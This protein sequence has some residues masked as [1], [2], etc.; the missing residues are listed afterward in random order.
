MTLTKTGKGR[1]TMTIPTPEEC[2][3][4]YKTFLLNLQSIEVHSRLLH[5]LL[6]NDGVYSRDMDDV[7]AVANF[8]EKL[9]K[10]Y[11]PGATSSREKID[12]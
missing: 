10:R 8:M 6:Q 3:V 9:L 1:Y 7:Q 12:G 5:Q 2:G 11:I 4:I